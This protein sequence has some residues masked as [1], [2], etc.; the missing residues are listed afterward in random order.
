MLGKKKPNPSLVSGVYY[1]L[2]A[3]ITKGIRGFDRLGPNGLKLDLNP[4]INGIG[5]NGLACFSA[6][7]KI[8]VQP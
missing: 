2:N 5:L 3:A 1:C 8:K 4:A 7:S 6:K